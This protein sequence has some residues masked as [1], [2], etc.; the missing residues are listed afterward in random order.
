MKV[1]SKLMTADVRMVR[2]R[3]DGRRLVLEGV[4]KEIMPMTVELEPRD[5]IAFASAVTRPLRASIASRL[6]E[7]LR[8]R[9]APIEEEPLVAATAAPVTS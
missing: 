1:V 5:V 9:V 3:L 4:V 8:S 2:V 6:P 7:P